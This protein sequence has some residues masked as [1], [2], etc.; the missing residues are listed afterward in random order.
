MSEFEKKRIKVGIVDLQLNN[1][2]SIVQASKSVG[3]KTTIIKKN[4]KN[5]NFDMIIIPGVGAFPKAMSY[6]TK[7]RIKERLI[8]FSTKKK[9]IIFGICL[10]MQLLLDSSNEFQYTEGLGL[11]KGKV[12]KIRKKNVIVPHTNWNNIH[13][14]KKKDNFLRKDIINKKLYFTHSYYCD[15]SDQI[16]ICSRSNHQGFE[17][18][19]SI[20]KNNIFGTQFH[21]EKSGLAGLK[22]LKDLIKYI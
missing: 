10:G 13:L 3:F 8:E 20:K 21:P 19:S 17:F 9:S 18:C 15:P 4:K 2:F 7:T 22:I 1:I 12:K 6:L 16:D 5:Y 14:T 11:I